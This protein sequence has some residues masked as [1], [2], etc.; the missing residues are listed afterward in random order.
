LRRGFQQVDLGEY[1]GEGDSFHSFALRWYGKRMHV[2]DAGGCA[3]AIVVFLYLE[4][5]SDM[6][7]VRYQEQVG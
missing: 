1:V 7:A 4:T 5:Y 6:L 3:C 2:E